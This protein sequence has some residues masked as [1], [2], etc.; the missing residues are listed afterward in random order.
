MMMMMMMMV[1]MM[2]TVPHTSQ[3]KFHKIAYLVSEPSW[4]E[5]PPVMPPF[6]STDCHATK[7]FPSTT[8]I[9]T[10]LPHAARH[11]NLGCGSLLRRFTMVHMPNK[12]LCLGANRQED[13]SNCQKRIR[14]KFHRPFG[15]TLEVTGR[16]IG[17]DLRERMHSFS[18]QRFANDALVKT[19]EY[20]LAGDLVQH[21]KTVDR[22]PH[23]HLTATQSN[24]QKW[25]DDI[26]RGARPFVKRH[27]WN[28][29]CMVTTSL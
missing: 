1:M 25:F 6:K 14:R 11:Q 16:D 2:H 29:F 9:F 26:R 18:D 17:L 8:F 13:R 4:M 12:Q 24:S 23:K 28:A 21:V 7:P 19:A 15:P 5:F 20:G 10:F 3:T 27:T 22:R